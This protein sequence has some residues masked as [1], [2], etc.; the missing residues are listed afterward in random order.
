[1]YRICGTGK[2]LQRASQVNGREVWESSA[3]PPAIL[4]VAAVVGMFGVGLAEESWPRGS[5]GYGSR[6]FERKR[7][8]E[9]NW[10]F[11]RTA[12]DAGNR[13]HQ[14]SVPGAK[15]YVVRPG[16]PSRNHHTS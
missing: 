14:L 11:Y 7:A 13:A 12:V 15:Q 8:V 10:D 3:E 6:A 1:M 2:F 4:E 16:G 5:I 9:A